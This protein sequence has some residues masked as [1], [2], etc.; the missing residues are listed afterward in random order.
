MAKNKKKA[1]K[2]GDRAGWGSKERGNHSIK[3]MGEP[4]WATA[5]APF[6]SF[7]WQSF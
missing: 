2:Q 4:R 6:L 5:E 1:K 7:F 3:E